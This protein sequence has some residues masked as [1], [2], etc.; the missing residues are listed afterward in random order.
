[1]LSVEVNKAATLGPLIHV[2]NSFFD[3]TYDSGGYSVDELRW[4]KLQAPA[5]RRNHVQLGRY[6][7]RRRPRS[8]AY[9]WGVDLTSV[10]DETAAA[11]TSVNDYFHWSRGGP[12]EQSCTLVGLPPGLHFLYI[13][14]KDQQRLREPRHRGI[15]AGGANV[16]P[17]TC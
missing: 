3:F 2:F 13:E 17:G 8:S 11:A 15:Q 5:G 12:L 7:H 10:A 4:I 16:Q 6:R 1:M 14:A 9:R